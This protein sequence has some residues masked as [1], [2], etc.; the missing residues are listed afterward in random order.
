M[1]EQTISNPGGA[2]KVVSDYRL[3]VDANTGELLA[4]GQRVSDCRC[5]VAIAK[6]EVLEWVVPTVS[7]PLSVQQ[8]ATASVGNLFAGV[9][10]KAGAAGQ[11][12][13]V[14]HEGIAQV[15]VAATTPA[16]GTVLVKPG[17]TAGKGST[18]AALDATTVTGTVIATALGAKDA[19]NLAPA[20][21]KQF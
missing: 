13:P 9:A 3:L 10:L 16:F 21:V 8:M 5:S 20:F 6:G 17:T 12:I 7:V 2:H 14:C 19:N 18:S 1:A 11:F 4:G 15:D